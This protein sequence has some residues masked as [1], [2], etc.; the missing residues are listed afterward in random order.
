MELDALHGAINDSLEFAEVLHLA[1]FCQTALGF[2][3]TEPGRTAIRFVR[4]AHL[5]DLHQE[6]LYDK[7]LHATGLPE[8]ALRMNVK[9]KVSRLDRAECASFFRRFTLSGLAVRE[10]GFRRSFWEGPL[11]AAV[12]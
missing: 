9:M 2:F 11:V 12:G 8:D 5:M 7:F 10:P 3:G 1:P 6:R 4:L